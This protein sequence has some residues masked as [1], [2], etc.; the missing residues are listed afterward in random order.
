MAGPLLVVCCSGRL[1]KWL[2]QISQASCGFYR[3]Y[4]TVCL[5]PGFWE[6]QVLWHTPGH[7]GWVTDSAS[8]LWDIELVFPARFSHNS[9]FLQS[10]S[11]NNPLKLSWLEVA[12]VTRDWQFPQNL[13]IR[14][15]PKILDRS[16]L[17]KMSH[18]ATTF[19]D[20]S[21]GADYTPYS[22]LLNSSN[23]L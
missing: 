22:W 12:M 7:C 16:D 17:T 4:Y 13:L 3:E 11:L 2:H 10:A 15:I 14:Q 1:S 9:S 5:C 20:N 19:Q 23:C 18:F 8:G 21:D 6:V